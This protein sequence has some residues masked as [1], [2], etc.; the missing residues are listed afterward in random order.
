M[1]ELNDKLYAL[2]K[3][4]RQDVRRTVFEA[5]VPGISESAGRAITELLTDPKAAAQRLRVAIDALGAP[6]HGRDKPGHDGS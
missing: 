4:V 6:R 2:P 1:T 5:A 3:S